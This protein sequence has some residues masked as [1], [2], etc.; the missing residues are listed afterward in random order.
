MLNCIH[1]N[2]YSYGR[3]VKWIS[4]REKE[5][6]SASFLEHQCNKSLHYK[7]RDWSLKGRL[8]IELLQNEFEA[9]LLSVLWLKT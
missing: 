7:K 6:G 1:E 3:L 5:F 2:L 9:S 4:E 8:E